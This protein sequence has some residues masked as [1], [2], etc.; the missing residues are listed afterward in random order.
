MNLNDP[1]WWNGLYPGHQDLDHKHIWMEENVVIEGYQ[2]T[3]K[4]KR[5][6]CKQC[7]RVKSY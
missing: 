5:Q 2:S 1:K 6:L 7:F 4:V 3:V